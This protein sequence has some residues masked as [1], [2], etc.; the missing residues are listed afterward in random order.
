MS[1]R[2]VAIPDYVSINYSH[3]NDNRRKIA[4]KIRTLLN[5]LS[6]Y[7]PLDSLKQTLKFQ[8][9]FRFSIPRYYY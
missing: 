9:R 1:F 6:L 8:K 7:K 5:H 3:Y 2:S 4:Q